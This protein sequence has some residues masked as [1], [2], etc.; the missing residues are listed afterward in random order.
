MY[1]LKMFFAYETLLGKDHEKSL[2]GVVCGWQIYTEIEVKGI[3]SG[4]FG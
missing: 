4:S 2:L 3:G 1:V